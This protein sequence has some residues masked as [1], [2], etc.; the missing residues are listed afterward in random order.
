MPRQTANVVSQLRDSTTQWE[1]FLE[2]SKANLIPEVTPEQIAAAATPQ[3]KEKLRDKQSLRIAQERSLRTIEDTVGKRVAQNQEALQK[4][5][6]AALAQQVELTTREL[7][8]YWPEYANEKYRSKLDRELSEYCV[9]AGWQPH[10]VQGLATSSR[11][12][13]AYTKAML[14]DRMKAGNAKVKA[15][16]AGGATETA[17]QKSNVVD[18]MARLP[19]NPSLQDLSGLV[20]ITDGN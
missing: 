9:D 18:L 17:P 20:S 4:Q 7:T 6:Q 2:N 3:E 14:F 15:K 16:V 8:D 12:Y 13:I 1:Q 19:K 11:D 5:H 10:E